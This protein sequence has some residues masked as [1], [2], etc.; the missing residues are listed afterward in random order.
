MQAMPRPG[1]SDAPRSLQAPLAITPSLIIPGVY[2]AYVW[3]NVAIALWFGPLSLADI[4]AF[5]AGCKAR[6]QEH[7][8][9]MS[10]VNIMVPGGKS[11]P[12]PEA[13]EELGRIMREYEA[14]S[15]EVVVVIPGAGFWASALRG[16]IT[17]VSMIA[18]RYH[19]HIAANFVQV[20]ELL[21]EPHRARTGVELDPKELLRAIRWVEN[22]GKAAA[23]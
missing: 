21:P 5:E 13:R 9:G 18:P 10:L 15:A 3:K 7:P 4:P 8:K 23:A 16:L 11:M 2:S 17:A 14:Y 22:Q 19:L 12:S 1:G 6:C 20:A